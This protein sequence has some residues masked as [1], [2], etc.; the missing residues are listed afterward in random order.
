MKTSEESLQELWNTTKWSNLP[1][2]A[3]PEGKEKEK[4]EEII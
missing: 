1:I 2:I 3:A 4:E